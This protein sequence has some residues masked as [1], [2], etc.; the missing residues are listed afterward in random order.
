MDRDN[1]RWVWNK[2]EDSAWLVSEIGSEINIL[3]IKKGRMRKW[4]YDEITPDIKG[5]LMQYPS[6]VS[7][8][9]TRNHMLSEVVPQTKFTILQAQ[10][11]YIQLNIDKMLNIKPSTRINL[12][13][14][15]PRFLR[16]WK[17]KII[18]KR[19]NFTRIY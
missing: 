18:K 11:T 4:K 17:M 12:H 10:V 19:E 7:L 5:K 1:P 15:V 8:R 16:N 13:T 14:G 2:L 6:K 9:K 3:E